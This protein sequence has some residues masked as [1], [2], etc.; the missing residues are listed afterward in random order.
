MGKVIGVVNQKGGVGKTTTAAN[1]G[2]G[3]AQ[4][5][6]K[7]LLIDMDPQGSLSAALGYQ[8]TDEGEYLTISDIFGRIIQDAEFPANYGILKQP[9]GVDLMPANIDLAAMEVSI[10]NV[11][12]RERILSQYV[13]MIRDSYDY[14]LIDCM[15]SLGMITINVLAAAD[16]VIIPVQAAYLP[17]KG[18]QQLLQT[19]GRVKKQIN[20]KLEI[21]GILLTLVDKRTRYGR[22][23]EQLLRQN[24]GRKL[25]IYETP[26]PLSVRAAETSA[27][28]KSIFLHNPK[29]TVAEAYGELT[30]AVI[31][32]MGME[33]VRGD[34]K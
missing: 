18:L 34:D 16:S 14:V 17:V 23:I 15:P 7:V 25:N 32:A 9:E 6:K 12:S 33:G 20:P 28:G 4:E 31:Q 26:I 10:V 19:I 5:G 30:Q 27:E 21:E 2:I 11:M 29:G 24:Y 3:L 22:E 13:D 8:D 1:L